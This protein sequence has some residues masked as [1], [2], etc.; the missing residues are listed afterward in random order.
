MAL[1]WIV[2]RGLRHHNALHLERACAAFLRH[3]SDVLSLRTIYTASLMRCHT[4]CCIASAAYRAYNTRAAS[5]LAV[6]AHACMPP[7]RRLP[8][9]TAAFLTAYAV[10]TMHTPLAYHAPRCRCLAFSYAHTV[11]SHTTCLLHSLLGRCISLVA[12]AA[13]AAPVLHRWSAFV[14]LTAIASPA[15]S[16]RSRLIALSLASIFA[17]PVSAFLRLLPAAGYLRIAPTAF[18]QAHLAAPAA[19]APH[20]SACLRVTT[21][22]RRCVR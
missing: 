14:P 15:F 22:P 5:I 17:F 12:P 6:T 16:R 8:L 2:A 18:P 21:P 1:C 7:P 20:R 4:H 13:F 19:L 10:Y 9:A 11:P 3:Y